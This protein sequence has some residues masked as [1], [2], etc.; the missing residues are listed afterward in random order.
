MNN[1]FFKKQKIAAFLAACG[2]VTPRTIGWS[3]I[4]N[5]GTIYSYASAL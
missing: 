4:R 1:W 3:T 2:A 5:E